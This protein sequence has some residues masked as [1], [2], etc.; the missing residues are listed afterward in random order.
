M[1]AEQLCFHTQF[2]EGK[3]NNSCVGSWV[4]KTDRALPVWRE[5]KWCTRDWLAGDA[6]TQIY[7]WDITTAKSLTI[8]LISR[9]VV[10][11][12][13]SDYGFLPLKAAGLHSQ[14]ELVLVFYPISI[15]SAH[16]LK[17]MDWQLE[18]WSPLVM[19]L[20]TIELFSLERTFSITESNR[21]PNTAHCQVHH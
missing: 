9:K 14:S 15:S 3:Q 17:L 10:W 19:H 5:V 1:S 11:K 18:R 20:R 12:V 8:M 2:Q 16:W 4:M 7:Q 13:I 6:Q 21:K